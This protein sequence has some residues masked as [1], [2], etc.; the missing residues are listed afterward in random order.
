MVDQVAD[1]FRTT[2]KVNTQE[3]VKNWGQHCGDIE[4]PGYL[5]NESVPVSLVL[6]L[7][8]THDRVGSSIDPTLNGHLKYPNNLDQSLN[9]SVVDKIRKYRADYNNRPPSVVSF[10]PVIDSTSDRLHSEFVRFHRAVFSR[11]LT[12]KVG[13]TLVKVTVLRINLNRHEKPKPSSRRRQPL[14]HVVKNT[15]RW[16]SVRIHDNAARTAFLKLK[17]TTEAP[18]RKTRTHV[19]TQ[20]PRRRPPHPNHTPIHHTN[21]MV[22]CAT[23]GRWPPQQHPS[24]HEKPKPSSVCRRPL[25]HVEEDVALKKWPEPWLSYANGILETKGN[26][27]SSGVKAPTARTNP[28][29]ISHPSTPSSSSGFTSS[30]ILPYMVY[31][32]SIKDECCCLL[33]IDEAKANIKPIYEC[34]CNERL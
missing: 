3:V 13:L 18:Q 9:D 1:F 24:R 33:W 12:G 10:M 16:R 8:I 4:I 30:S 20:I 25:P 17:Q 31:F 29:S 6:D 32:E 15:L 28:K 23:Q 21:A 26:D 2:H 19:L 5:A 34:R 22:K 11:K 14:T 27:G 7:R